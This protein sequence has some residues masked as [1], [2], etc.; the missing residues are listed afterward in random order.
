MSGGNLAWGGRSSS[1]APADAGEVKVT[2]NWQVG[3]SGRVLV[4]WGERV[5]GEWS[6]SLRLRRATAAKKCWTGFADGA[7]TCSCGPGSI[8]SRA[9]SSTSS[10]IGNRGHH[11]Q[12]TKAFDRR[13]QAIAQA[14]EARAATWRRAARLSAQG[15]VAVVATVQLSLGEELC[16]LQSTDQ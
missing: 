2:A 4:Q 12:E 1:T 15:L 16:E 5:I 11:L 6:L 3:N 8:S 14:L 7:E 9:S 13:L 10:C